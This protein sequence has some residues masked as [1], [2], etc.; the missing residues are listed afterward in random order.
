MQNNAFPVTT[1]TN[2]VCYLCGESGTI[3]YSNCVDHLFGAPGEWSFKKC[4]AI[5]CGHIWLDPRPHVDDI[6]K[7]YQNYYT[8]DANDTHL[9]GWLKILRTVLHRFSLFGLHRERQRYKR[10]YLDDIVHGSLL[11]VGCGNGKRLNRLRN[12]GWKV[13]GQ[14]VDPVAYEFVTHNLGILVHLGSLESLSVSEQYD[15]ILMSHVIEHVYDPAALLASCFRLLKQ[16]GLI[17]LLTPNANSYGHRKFRA[18]WRGLEPPRHLHL[19]TSKTL[20]RLMERT[21]FQCQK[22]RTTPITAFSIG[23]NSFVTTA[24]VTKQQQSITYRDIF[25]GFWFQFLARIV[26]V[27]DKQSGEECVLIA[28]KQ[29]TDTELK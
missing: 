6:D 14:E 26:F 16:D 4:T 29:R 24:S 28:R 1:E 10:M 21:G 5:N 20:V 18:C 12:L 13:T 27:L 3:I 9:T 15:V 11:E 19:F 2:I 23:Q 25:R 22:S 7:V 17:I 8:H